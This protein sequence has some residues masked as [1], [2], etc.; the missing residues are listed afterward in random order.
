MRKFLCLLYLGTDP[1]ETGVFVSSLSPAAAMMNS[2][3][4]GS[5]GKL[6]PPGNLVINTDRET[7]L[8]K[9]LRTNSNTPD[10]ILSRG[11]CLRSC[12]LHG[13]GNM[14][15][16]F[17]CYRKRKRCTN[18]TSQQTVAFFFLI[19]LLPFQQSAVPSTICLATF[20]LQTPLCLPP[21]LA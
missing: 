11:S 16:V 6:Y 10:C 7:G 15:C 5:L 8:R 4:Q 18:K 13:A 20:F 1:L 21:Y 17:L 19:L 9:Y 2:P 3:A 12:W 14:A